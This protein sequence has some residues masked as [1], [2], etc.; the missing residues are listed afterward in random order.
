MT[1][2]LKENDKTPDKYWKELEVPYD[3]LHLDWP[4][5][6]PPDFK[7]I[8]ELDKVIQ[9]LIQRVE[10]VETY[11]TTDMPAGKPFVRAHER[12]TVGSEILHKIT[13]TVQLLGSRLEQIEHRLEEKKE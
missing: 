11:I 2:Y 3:W 10:A 1:I 13:Q 5:R 6:E 12:P 9:P 4:K 8:V 7:L